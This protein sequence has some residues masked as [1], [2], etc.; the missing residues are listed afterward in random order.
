MQNLNVK[1]GRMKPFKSV[2]NNIMTR[3]NFTIIKHAYNTYINTFY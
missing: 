1:Y 2:Y 3:S